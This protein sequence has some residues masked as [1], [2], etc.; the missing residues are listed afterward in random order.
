M[1]LVTWAGD[2]GLSDHV[3]LQEMHSRFARPP[4]R[5]PPPPRSPCSPPDPT[6]PPSHTTQLKLADTIE[7]ALYDD[8]DGLMVWVEPETLVSSVLAKW[9]REAFEAGGC[10]CSVLLTQGGG[11]WCDHGCCGA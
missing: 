4:P 3:A 7:L 8:D 2:M 5:H 10:S 11:P 1:G 6:P 9:T